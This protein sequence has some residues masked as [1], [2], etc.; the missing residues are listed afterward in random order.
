MASKK[1]PAKP[2]QSPLRY[3]TAA[4][5]HGSAASG[6]RY[7]K[8]GFSWSPEQDL[9]FALGWPHFK[10]L[11]D[12]HPDDVDPE[13]AARASFR[14]EY[15]DHRLSWPRAAAARLVRAMT[16]PVV[17]DHQNL[18]PETGK[19]RLTAETDAA[20]RDGADVTSDEARA[21][22]ARLFAM[23]SSA[24]L[25]NRFGPALL[26]LEA[27]VGPASVLD[28]AVTSLAEYTPQRMVKALEPTADAVHAMGFM[29]LRVQDAE[30]TQ[31]RARLEDLYRKS[32]TSDTGGY[33][34]RALDQILHGATGC[35]GAWPG[36][37]IHVL[38]DPQFVAEGRRSKPDHVAFDLPDPRIVFLGGEP[39]YEIERRL[40]RKYD[41]LK[42]PKRDPLI[43]ERM[44][45][46][47][48]PTT[49]DLVL[50]LSA[51]SKARK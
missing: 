33:V 26:L 21:A 13:R 44:G 43:V 11:V 35:A 48:S 42:P 40:W 46:I 15:A 28:A 20:F 47:R 30:A 49:V 19:A 29:L 25:A 12:G 36:Y 22:V 27:F 5:T 38:D 41:F 6:A 37:R 39:V 1:A 2:A 23:P 9:E 32:T 18:D 7:L 8:N 45:A 16:V 17:Y 51:A 31:Q 10:K 34:L 14:E 4:L 3:A 50:E 24:V